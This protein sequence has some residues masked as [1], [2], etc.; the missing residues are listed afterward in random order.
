MLKKYLISDNVFWLCGKPGHRLHTNV[1]KTT[2]LVHMHLTMPQKAVHKSSK[3]TVFI[4]LLQ[5]FLYTVFEQSYTTFTSVKSLVVHTI[6]R[7]Y[8]YD[9]YSNKGIN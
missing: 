9:N 7:A 6:H 8:I 2:R 1:L 3:K 4:P 5:P